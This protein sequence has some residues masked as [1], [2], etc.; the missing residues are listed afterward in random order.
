MDLIHYVRSKP[1][2]SSP[3]SSDHQLPREPHQF[4]D[5]LPY[6]LT[7]LASIAGAPVTRWCEGE[8]G[9]SRR[10]WR[11]IA[12]L[13]QEG[14]LQSAQ[15]ASRLDLDRVRTSRA[16][17]EL[18]DKSLIKRHRHEDN[19]RFVQVA[20]T[21]RGSDLVAQLWPKI[22]AHHLRLLDVLSDPEWFQLQ[23]LLLKL[24]THARHINESYS[25]L[26]K[27]N[28]QAGLR[29]TPR[30]EP[31]SNFGKAKKILE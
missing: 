8:F 17:R 20:L 30:F 23:Q 9:I 6:R 15:L 13:A 27:A 10:Q 2:T 16:L 28:R 31:S 14:S 18:E 25:D 26:P 4:S 7:R 11:V 12:T 24:Q 19:A 1:L 21:A 3:I 29:R 5:L 22:S